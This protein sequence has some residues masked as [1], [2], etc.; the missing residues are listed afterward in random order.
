M[1]PDL[2]KTIFQA[3]AGVYYIAVYFF[4]LEYARKKEKK[5]GPG[6]V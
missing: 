5:K 3:R 1:K 4:R 2:L 6:I